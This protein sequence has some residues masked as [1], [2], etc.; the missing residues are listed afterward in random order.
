VRSRLKVLYIRS[1]GKPLIPGTHILANIA[2]CDPALEV[3]GNVGWEGVGAVFDRVVGNAAVGIHH[4]GLGNRAGWA[5]IQTASAAAAMVCMGAIG[6]QGQARENF[7]Q[8]DPRP[9]G[10]RNQ[11]A[12]FGD[13]S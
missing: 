10:A 8:K 4:K 13:P 6:Q 11:I 1:P 2:A 9:I 3:V 12:V 7:T 5:G